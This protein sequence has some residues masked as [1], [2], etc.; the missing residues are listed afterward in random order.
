MLF[1]CISSQVAVEN[2]DEKPVFSDIDSDLEDAL[3]VENWD[4]WEGEEKREGKD[5]EDENG[6]RVVF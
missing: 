5:E 3:E 2:A 6:G 1:N 4:E